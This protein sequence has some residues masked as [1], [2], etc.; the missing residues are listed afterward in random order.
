M[1]YLYKIYHGLKTS[2]DPY[3]LKAHHNLLGKDTTLCGITCPIIKSLF[4]GHTLKYVEV[5]EDCTVT[6]D[7]PGKLKL[8]LGIQTL[9][10]ARSLEGII[11]NYIYSCSPLRGDSFGGGPIS[12][13]CSIQKLQYIIENKRLNGTK[14]CKNCLWRD[15]S[16]CILS[17]NNSIPISFV[18]I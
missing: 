6:S 14:I 15:I 12:V 10:T 5:V 18:W 11:I 2:I 7:L 13:N 17:Y 16:V 3:R 8:H 9:I 4:H 1:C